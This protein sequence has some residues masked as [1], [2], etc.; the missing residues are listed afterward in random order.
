VFQTKGFKFHNFIGIVPEEFAPTLDH[1]ND[2]AQWFDIN[3][4]PKPLH[5]GTERLLQNARHVIDQAAE[6]R[7]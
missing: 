3:N 2:D 5:F 7:A 1:E 4:L 6:E